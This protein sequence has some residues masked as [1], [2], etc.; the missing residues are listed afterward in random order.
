[1][2]NA[3]WKIL[4]EIKKIKIHKLKTLTKKN[5]SQEMDS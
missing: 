4:H 1:M 5:K 3:K 2:Y